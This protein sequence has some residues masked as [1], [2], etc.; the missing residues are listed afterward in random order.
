LVRRPHAP[1]RRLPHPSAERSVRQRVEVVERDRWSDDVARNIE[2]GALLKRA[3]VQSPEVA[4]P[5]E[6]LENGRSVRGD[7]G[8]IRSSLALKCGQ[9]VGNEEP[10][11]GVGI[12]V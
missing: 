4:R 8:L 7:P 11:R 9:S 2:Y 1:L 12:A 5:G 6:Q 10:A 3:A